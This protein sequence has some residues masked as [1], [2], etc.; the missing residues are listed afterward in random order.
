MGERGVA[1][2]SEWSG[3][4]SPFLVVGELDRIEGLDGGGGGWG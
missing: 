4:R 3:V 1:G 2:G